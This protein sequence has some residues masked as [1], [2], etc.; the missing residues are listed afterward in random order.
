M[1]IC[2]QII[3]LDQINTVGVHNIK[4]EQ[5]AMRDPP[6]V[7][8]RGT[9]PFS[10]P[11]PRNFKIYVNAIEQGIEKI[12]ERQDIQ[13]PVLVRRMVTGEKSVWMSDLHG[14]R[15][16]IKNSPINIDELRGNWR[17][18]SNPTVC[19]VATARNEGPYILDWI[20]YH[21]SI[22]FTKI[23]IFH[24]DVTDLMLDVIDLFKCDGK[25]I[26]IENNEEI[27]D[28]EVSPEL[29]KNPQWR[30]YWL[31]LR[32][33]SI[34]ECDYIMFMDID[35]YLVLKR[36]KSV[37]ELVSEYGFLDAIGIN[38]L[39]FGS[40]GMQDFRAEPVFERF[41]YGAERKWHY[42]GIVKSIGK[43]KSISSLGGAH[44]CNLK[45]EHS[46]YTYTN[47]MPVSV[48]H[49]PEIIDH[50]VAQ[51]NHYKIMS[52]QDYLLRKLRGDVIVNKDTLERRIKYNTGYY[53]MMDRNDE[54]YIEILDN[55]SEFRKIK[56][57]IMSSRYARQ[58]MEKVEVF[59]KWLIANH[60]HEIPSN[61]VDSV[62]R[63]RKLIASKDFHKNE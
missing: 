35:E 49:N 53:L 55:I 14:N 44:I 36:H 52:P 58:L 62:D 7:Y 17:S 45:P 56:S 46:I 22:G 42:N 40:S 33:D 43:I 27:E 60:K 59:T 10:L 23:V 15:T 54:K 8:P 11:T 47:G 20:S 61:I 38:W 34:R 24:N 28:N 21:I 3:D 50:S 13:E 4:A 41:L 31:S 32:M 25:V 19:L 39:C 29:M 48:G 5:L 30:A 26:H 16:I 6:M 63:E 57:D 18:V 9:T 37:N 12:I 1:E 51:I 2:N